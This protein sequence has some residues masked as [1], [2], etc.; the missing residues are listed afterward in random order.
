MP[1]LKPR[2][3]GLVI[4]AGLVVLGVAAFGGKVIGRES[5][6]VPS[7]EE[8]AAAF[9]REG[10]AATDLPLDSPIALSV[11]RALPKDSKIASVVERVDTTKD[12]GVDAVKV[13]T[14]DDRTGYEVTVYRHFAT[15]ELAG[16]PTADSE[17]GRVWISAT[18]QDL[19]SIY[20]LSGSGVGLRVAHLSPRAPAQVEE[21]KA[22]AAAVAADPVVVEEAAK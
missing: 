14:V 15:E 22:I 17:A 19:T 7:G 6:M 12:N 1:S 5:P 16:L 10:V 3:L 2:T 4:I 13:S 21:L 9:P 11:A 8:E 20:Y 18:D